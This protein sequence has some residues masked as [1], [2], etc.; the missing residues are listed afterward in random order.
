LGLTYAEAAAVIDVPA[1]T[2]MSRISR[3]RRAM[4]E[5][6][7]ETNVRPMKKRRG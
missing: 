3:A 6:L 2:V 1:G 4:I 7:G 5:R